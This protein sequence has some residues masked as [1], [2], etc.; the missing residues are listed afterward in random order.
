MVRR[1]YILLAGLF[2]PSILFSQ[3]PEQAYFEWTTL[4]F[5]K[6]ELEHRREKLTTNLIN[7]DKSG[8][9]LIPARDGFSYGET[10]RQ[11]DDFYYFTGLELP[12]SILV[13]DLAEKSAVVYTPERD[14]RFESN[15]RPN[16]FPG[17]PLLYD[18]AIW[19]TKCQNI[20]CMNCFIILRNGNE[21]SIIILRNWTTVK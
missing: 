1:F 6:E 3:T 21:I 12:N 2:L 11:L 5:S 7:Q 17:R 15:S 14:L 9:V 13:L 16:D 8:I 18:S 10:F 20:K 4:P 19:S